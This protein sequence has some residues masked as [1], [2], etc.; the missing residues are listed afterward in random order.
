[1]KLI[2][3]GAEAKIYLDAKKNRVVKRRLQ[4][5][6]R[7]DIM[8]KK[9]R[10]QRTRREGKILSKLS[11]I[12]PDV[13]GVD[14]K[15]MEI[16]MNYVEGPLVRDVLEECDKGMRGKV[17]KLVGSNV[18]KMHVLDVAHGDLTTSNM[19]LN[20]NDVKLIDFG[21]GF[22]TKKLEDKAVDVH[23]LKHALESKHYRHSDELFEAFLKGYKTGNPDWLAVI[24]R[25]KLVEKRGRYK[26]RFGS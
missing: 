15:G 26:R 7:L 12:C 17:M 16:V 4:K 20:D 9:I 23:L 22:V 25:L 3:N 21:L 10:V 18:G 24:E 14:D 19:I 6:Y 8:D 5:S 2:G 11:G 1:M 13:V